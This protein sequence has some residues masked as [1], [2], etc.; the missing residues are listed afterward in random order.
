M[1][2]ILGEQMSNAKNLYPEKEVIERKQVV[3]YKDGKMIP[4]IDL[5]YYMGRSKTASTVYASIWVYNKGTYTSGHGKASG[6]GYDKKSA[7][8]AA[9]IKDAGIVLY[10][11]PYDCESEDHSKEAYIAGVG[12]QAVEKALFAIAAALGYEYCII[13]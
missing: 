9:A 2:A 6:Y 10:G 12:G 3:A 1:K 4:I 11:S 5:R 13:V 8:A 7:A